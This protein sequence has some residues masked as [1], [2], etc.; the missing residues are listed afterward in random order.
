MT[1][2]CRAEFVVEDRNYNFGNNI[3]V[4]SSRNSRF[5]SCPIH[6]RGRVEFVRQL[7]RSS[8]NGN[9]G[10]DR[11]GIWVTNGCRA[12]FKLLPN[13]NYGNN[14]NNYRNN[15]PI[16]SCSSKN[17]QHRFCP[18]DTSGGVRLKKQKSRASCAG[19]WGHDRNGIWVNNGC[20]A[21]FELYINNHGHNNN[22]GRNNHQDYGNNS[23]YSNQNNKVVCS[24]IKHK[25]KVCP[26]PMGSRVQLHK[27][28][29]RKNCT[30][31]WGYNRK[32]IWVD[33][34]CRAEFSLF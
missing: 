32:E 15:N 29:S 2:G 5:Q 1:N 25:R 10:Y 18:A 28:L 27:Q 13:N 21:T 8:C 22:Y 20:R 34:G 23:G 7:S 16:I 12:K 14:N 19:N 4:C 24:S 6:T 9:W 11:Q 33:G 31:R 30:G 26:I 3:V 17:H